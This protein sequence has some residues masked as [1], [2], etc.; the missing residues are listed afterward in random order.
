VPVLRPFLLAILGAFVAAAPAAP[1]PGPAKKERRSPSGGCEAR[2]HHQKLEEPERQVPGE[3][4][5]HSSRVCVA[6]GGEC[7]P[8]PA[9]DDAR[10]GDHAKSLA[11]RPPA[12]AVSTARAAPTEALAVPRPADLRAGLLALPPPARRCA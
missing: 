10:A 1:V 7:A 12:H 5:A 4:S 9:G 3:T 2:G 11:R 8:A 6:T